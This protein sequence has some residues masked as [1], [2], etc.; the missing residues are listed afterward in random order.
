MS[1]RRVALWIFVTLSALYLATGRGHFIGTDEVG[2]FRQTQA[3]WRHGDLDVGRI[4][5]AF[6]GRGGRWYSQYA[7]GQSLLALPLY[8]LGDMVRRNA[9]PQWRAAFAGE[10]LGQEPTRW[11]GDVEI[12][13]VNLLNAFV[14]A[15]LAALFYLASRLWGGGVASSML[16]ALLVGTTTQ[17]WLHATMFLQHPLEALLLLLMLHLLMLDRERPDFRLRLG[18]GLAGALLVNIR[19]IS[20]LAFPALGIYLAA[21]IVRRK[22]ALVREVPPLVLPIAIAGVIYAWVGWLKFATFPPTY[23]NEGFETP[24]Y[25]GAFGYLFSPG[26]SIFVYSPLLIALPWVWQRRAESWTVLAISV[27]YLICFSKYKMWH[28]LWSAIGPRY[29]LPLEPLLLLP[30]AA[31]WTRTGRRAWWLIAPLAAAGLMMQ[32]LSVSLN[33]SFVYSR[34]GWPDY[35][36]QYTFLFIPEL[37]PP[38]AYWRHFW[39]GEFIDLWVVKTWQKVGAGPALAFTAPLA[40]VVALGARKLWTLRNE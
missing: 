21:N 37:S 29:L 11:G 35:R 4:Q 14:V 39:A 27:A 26:M 16:A 6:P 40:A 38:V 7:V 20:A 3:I 30:L 9:A 1:D 24:L 23:N 28:G 32:I 12:F 19:L 13:F 34:E 5:N 18:A 2:V 33:W 15:A 22:G 8:G 10:S 36:P 31:W 25:H 17:L